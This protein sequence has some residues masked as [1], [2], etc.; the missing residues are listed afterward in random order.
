MRKTFITLGITTMLVIAC[1]SSDAPS[2]APDAAGG[3]KGE[4]LFRMNCV[5]CHGA[6][7]KL[8][9]NGAKDLTVSTLTK[10]EMIARVS[11]GKGT[12]QAY[13]NMLTTKEIEAVVDH[14][15]SLAVKQ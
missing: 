8:A 4:Q 2:D 1:G 5:L 6:S 7:G 13:K 10:A 9:F 11:N 15:R 12:M 14:V 3:S